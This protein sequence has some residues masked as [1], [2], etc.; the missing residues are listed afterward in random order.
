MSLYIC[1]WQGGVIVLDLRK[2]V[3]YVIILSEV[4]TQNQTAEDLFV[5]LFVYLF[6]VG[7]H[8]YDTKR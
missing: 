4:D 6:S 5:R 7:R 3:R 8:G 1:P 2:T